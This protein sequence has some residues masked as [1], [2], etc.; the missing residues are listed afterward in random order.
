MICL[1]FETT[2]KILYPGLIQAA[3]LSNKILQK[4]RSTAS[5]KS[6]VFLYSN[7]AQIRKIAPPN[8][9]ARFSCL[10]FKT[11]NKLDRFFYPLIFYGLI[12]L[13]KLLYKLPNRPDKLFYLL[14]LNALLA[15]QK[16]K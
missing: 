16:T 4:A 11:L 3:P 6:Y 7:F 9:F 2:F 14:A 8:M 1:Y 12:R 10:L 15:M 5:S 13:C